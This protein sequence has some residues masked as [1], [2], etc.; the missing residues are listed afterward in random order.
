MSTA[1]PV[2]PGDVWSDNDPRPAYRDRTVLVEYLCTEGDPDVCH[3]F[4]ERRKPH[5]HVTD[6]RT[7]RLHRIALDRFRPTRSNGYTLVSR[8][9]IEHPEQRVRWCAKHRDGWCAVFPDAEPDEGTDWVRTVC[10]GG[11]NF[12]GGYERRKPDCP[13]C[14]AALA[15]A[16]RSPEGEGR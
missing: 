15:E 3:V 9:V 11:I 1:P 10:I 8:R 4:L 13:E 14:I 5:A 12:P 2:Q 7:G 16:S 6:Q